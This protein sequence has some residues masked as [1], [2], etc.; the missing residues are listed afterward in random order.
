M[1]VKSIFFT[2]QPSYTRIYNYRIIHL[3]D[4]HVGIDEQ[5]T[6]MKA[7]LMKS[8]RHTIIESYRVAAQKILKN[9]NSDQL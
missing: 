6:F 3:V 8:D 1:P 7:K 4:G 5:T 2:L 9:I